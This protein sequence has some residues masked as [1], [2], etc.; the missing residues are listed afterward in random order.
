MPMNPP[1]TF[2]TKASRLTS[3]D[4]FDLPEIPAD[5]LEPQ[6]SAPTW[7]QQLAHAQILIRWRREES[8]H[9]VFPAENVNTHRNPEPF[10]M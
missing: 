3:E 7:E 8:K 6:Q 10:E 1:A 9:T 4:L 2:S 5:Y